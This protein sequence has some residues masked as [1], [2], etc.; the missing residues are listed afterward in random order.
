MML[1]EREGE[2]DYFRKSAVQEYG[3]LVHMKNQIE[4]YADNQ[5]RIERRKIRQKER[6]ER[7]EHEKVE[8]RKLLSKSKSVNEEANDRIKE[9]GI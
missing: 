5:N 6:Q 8:R 2:A 3:N 7:L 1:Q 9:L 4:I